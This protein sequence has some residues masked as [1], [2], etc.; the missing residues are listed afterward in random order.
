MTDSPDVSLQVGSTRQK[1]L[2]GA[3]VAIRSLGIAKVSAR[4]I[5]AE[6]QVNQALVF[7]HFGTVT[8]LLAAAFAQAT[9][10][11]VAAYQVVFDRVGSLREL[12]AVGRRLH[13]EEQDLGNVQVLA[14][15]LAGA[16]T[17][18]TLAPAVAAALRLWV[19]QIQEV[20]VRVLADSPLRPMT[21]PAGLARAV[22]AGFIGLEL[23]EGVDADGGRL[24]LEALE[25]LA[26]VLEVVDEL[27]PVARR[28]VAAKLRRA[29]R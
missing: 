10:A 22:S 21:D 3:M 17:D 4:T 12:L 25:Q 11:R 23:F 6:A 9:Q 13:R 18:A 19:D 8:E 14:Q 20:L 16:Q 28:A 5:A 27:G 7:Y 24:A 29:A 26:A 1:L 15:L 2:D